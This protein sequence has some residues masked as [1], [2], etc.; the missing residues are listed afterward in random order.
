MN[1]Y[2]VLKDLGELNYFLG[3]EASRTSKGIGLTQSKYASD[4]LQ[5]TNMADCTTCP[6]PMSIDAKLSQED[7]DFTDPTLYQSI[8]G[9]LQYLTF[10][11]PNIS[12]VVNRLS[13]YLI[14]PTIMHW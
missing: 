11:R 10:T 12:F 4:L 5:K 6:T 8:V 1:R 9:A 3:F 14:A 7:G 2:F 13:Q